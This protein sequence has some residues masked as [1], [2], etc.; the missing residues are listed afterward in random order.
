VK[1]NSNTNELHNSEQS[2][3]LKE[4][5]NHSDSFGIW[6]DWKMVLSILV[7]V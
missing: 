7:K 3:V 4:L 5:W 6:Y 2:Y 1:N